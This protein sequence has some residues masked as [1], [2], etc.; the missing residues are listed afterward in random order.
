MWSAGAWAR[1]KDTKM[2]YSRVRNHI[3]NAMV[4]SLMG[5]NLNGGGE[6]F[7]TDANLGLIAA[8]AEMLLQ[9]DEKS[10]SLLPA[11]PDEWKNGEIKKFRTRCGVNVHMKFVDGIV[12]EL[13]LTAD[14]EADITVYVNN[15][16][17]HVFL[18]K[19]ETKTIIKD[20]V[21]L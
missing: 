13:S 5:I 21:I 1:L 16:N 11:V 20:G 17:L 8:F 7:Q 12:T 10:I 19:N 14:R 6:F 2:A 15:Q 18:N 3:K 4:A 9:S